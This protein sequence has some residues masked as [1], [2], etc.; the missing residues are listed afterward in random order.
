MGVPPVMLIFVGR[1]EGRA[2]EEVR[3]VGALEGFFMGSEISRPAADGGGRGGGVCV[4]LGGSRRL[5]LLCCCD[6]PARG[7]T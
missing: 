4:F 1:T 2:G 5:R 3:V 6:G 7:G